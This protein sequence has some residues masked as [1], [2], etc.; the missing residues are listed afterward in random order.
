M[1]AFLSTFSLFSG[2]KVELAFANVSL[3]AQWTSKP[4]LMAVNHNA[5][6]GE[7]KGHG[8]KVKKESFW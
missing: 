4:V 3:T 2:Q 5:P 8:R 6:S 7:L 1:P